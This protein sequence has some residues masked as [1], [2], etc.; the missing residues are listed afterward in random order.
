MRLEG[1]VHVFPAKS[2]SPRSAQRVSLDLVAVST[3]RVTMAATAGAQCSFTFASAS[4]TCEWWS[5]RWWF[6]SPF[7]LLGSDLSTMGTGLAAVRCPSSTAQSKTVPIRRPTV[8]AWTSLPSSAM[9]TGR[10]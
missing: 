5:D 2:N 10:P 8:A 6:T 1:I 9:G 4:P 7:F 3:S